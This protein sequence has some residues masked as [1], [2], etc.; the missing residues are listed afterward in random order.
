MQNLKYPVKKVFLPSIDIE[1]IKMYKDS[2]D[3]RF[4]L[5]LLD[6]GL[7][8]KGQAAIS[9]TGTT[10]TGT[11]LQTDVVSL[12]KTT[13]SFGLPSSY[14]V[15]FDSDYIETGL[16]L[17]M[18]EEV[19][20]PGFDNTK[21]NREVKTFLANIANP[22]VSNGKWSVDNM[23]A[24][25]MTLLK[26]IE[27]AFLSR[28]AYD[29]LLNDKYS[30]TIARKVV[31][32]SR[33]LTTTVIKVTP[34]KSITLNQK[35]VAKHTITAV[36]T[37]TG[38]VWGAVNGLVTVTAAEAE[39][40]GVDTTTTLV[41]YTVS[42]TTHGATDT[43][44]FEA[45]T[46]YTLEP[47]GTLPDEG[48]EVQLLARVFHT[49]NSNNNTFILSQY[50][51]P[52]VLANIGGVYHVMSMQD[53]E[54]FKVSAA[55]I[56]TNSLLWV[57]SASPYVK[58]FPTSMD[59]NLNVRA[60]SVGINNASLENDGDVLLITKVIPGTT[61]TS[62]GTG[63]YP[64]LTGRQIAEHYRA[65]IL[66]DD[67]FDTAL[68]GNFPD[69]NEKYIK[70]EIAS[71]VP[72]VNLHGASH[73]DG[74]IQRVE[75]IVPLTAATTAKWDSPAS[76]YDVFKSGVVTSAAKTFDDLMAYLTGTATSSWK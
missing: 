9:V 4:T 71:R 35:S 22:S 33:C 56:T 58:I 73:A 16:K 47:V 42:S 75:I 24:M 34:G 31:A 36:A 54:N 69:V 32:L 17:T 57:M 14:L 45:G 6:S 1:K 23:E 68:A 62:N 48:K 50:K 7:S 21:N 26:D 66:G 59:V 29:Y 13:T 10:P 3:G 52:F 65:F 2:A 76:S 40:M 11:A 49:Y 12:A 37:G 18:Q 64:R 63:V 61:T 15:D 39:A 20:R 28:P 46:E 38:E 43:F 67:L 27:D 72:D 51:S 74:Y 8:I 25:K 19:E 53:F 44:K 41:N 60:F 55:T 30:P 70:Y 5:H